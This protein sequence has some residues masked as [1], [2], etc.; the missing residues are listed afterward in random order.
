MAHFKLQ[1]GTTNN[2]R[3][4][5]TKV[6]SCIAPRPTTITVQTYV[7]IKTN[8]RYVRDN[9]LYSLNS[10]VQNAMRVLKKHCLL[11]QNLSKALN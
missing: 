3:L 2:G 10:V 9:K 1:C 7:S 11:D 4:L 5:E 6:V 8:M